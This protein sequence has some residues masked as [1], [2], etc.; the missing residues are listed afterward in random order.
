VGRESLSDLDLYYYE[1]VGSATSPS[2]A[3]R[4]HGNA[5][6]FNGIVVG[7]SSTPAFADLDGDGDLDLVVG[8]GGGVHYFENVGNATSPSYAA[9]TSK[10]SDDDIFYQ[11]SNGN[12]NPIDGLDPP[13][14]E[15]M[16]ALRRRHL[17]GRG[18]RPVYEVRRGQVLGGGR[19]RVRELLRGVVFRSGRER[20]LKLRD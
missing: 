15:R 9:R 13:G 7:W 17:L 19:E 3:A 5:N 2:Y 14:R 8:D 1:N 18:R 11:Y 4:G 12:E 20:V 10:T 16:R 6:P